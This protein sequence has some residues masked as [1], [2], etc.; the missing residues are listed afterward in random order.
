MTL[1]GKL[2]ARQKLNILRQAQ[3]GESVSSFCLKYGISRKTFYKWQKRYE[4]SGYLKKALVEKTTVRTRASVHPRKVAQKTEQ[5]I[6]EI[7]AKQPAL[8]IPKIVELL[9][10][11]ADGKP[12][13]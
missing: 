9:P 3:K 7:I 6:L 11:T 4:L 13:V 12:R 8:S 10:K 5:L 1:R 2:T